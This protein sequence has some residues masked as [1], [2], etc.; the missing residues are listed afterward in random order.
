MIIAYVHMVGVKK[1]Q[2]LR[3]MDGQMPRTG[4]LVRL[5]KALYR[6]TTVTHCFNKFTIPAALENENYFADMPAV[7]ITLGKV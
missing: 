3:F 5:G 4:E 1:R 7:M 6:V 2:T